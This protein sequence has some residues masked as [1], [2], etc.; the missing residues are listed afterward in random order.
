MYNCAVNRGASFVT[1]API[2]AIAFLL[3]E[4]WTPPFGSLRLAGLVIL[5]P[6]LLLLTI[7]RLQ[8]GN[9]FSLAPEAR[10]L[11][12]YGLYSRIRNPVYVFG[13]FALAGLALY[14]N[15]PFLLLAFLVVIPLQIVRARAEARVLEEKF[16]DAYREYRA[17]TW[18]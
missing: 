18:F 3:W 17:R 4:F 9:S 14:I 16:G 7:A 13:T 10:E 8:L 12:T 1:F 15:M 6:S 5:I 2:L 11:V